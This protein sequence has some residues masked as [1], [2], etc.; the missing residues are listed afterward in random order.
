MRKPGCNDYIVISSVLWYSHIWMSYHSTLKEVTMGT[1]TVVNRSIPGVANALKRSTERWSDDKRV[2][3]RYLVGL[4]IFLA[5]NILTWVSV[6]DKS[7]LFLSFTLGYAVAAA[8]GF[9][10]VA[11]AEP[12]RKRHWRR[13]V[14]QHTQLGR[15]VEVPPVLDSLWNGA[16][17]SLMLTYKVSRTEALFSMDDNFGIVMDVIT[18]ANAIAAADAGRQ[19]QLRDRIREAITDGL[20]PAVEQAAEDARVDAENQAAAARER[21]KAHADYVD[22]LLAVTPPTRELA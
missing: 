9:T 3:L 1:S 17:A 16:V 10:V 4:P 13:L 6:T 2:G 5:A 7:W 11:I 19:T 20:R 12:V 22:G 21:E 15:I 8:V 14:R 18:Y